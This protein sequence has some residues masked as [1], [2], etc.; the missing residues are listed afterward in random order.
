MIINLDMQT[1]YDNKRPI[2]VN[3]IF[4]ESIRV[5]R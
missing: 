1:A 3:D 2:I 5:S 4:E